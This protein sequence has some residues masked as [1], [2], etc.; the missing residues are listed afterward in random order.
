MFSFFIPLH[1]LG[2]HASVGHE[3]SGWM[4][5]RRLRPFRAPEGLGVGVKPDT[6][7]LQLTPKYGY[8]ETDG[9]R[10]PAA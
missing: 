6:H 9:R 7:L 8:P 3:T 10:C 4:E 1:C 2:D 5:K